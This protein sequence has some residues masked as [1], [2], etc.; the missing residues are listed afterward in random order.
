MSSPTSSPAPDSTD[1]FV[2]LHVHTEYSM[3]D[4]AA[5]IGDLFTRASELGMPALAMTDH[6]YLYGAHEFWRKAQGTGVKPIIGLEAY[7][8]PGTH[9][10]DKT[11]VKWG[12][13][14]TRPG[15][16][17]SGSGAYTHMTL[18][19][20]NNN[21]LRN[22]FQMDSRA[23]LD[24][25]Y[26]KWPRLDRELIDQHG[27]G[28]I[29]T[30]GCPSSEIQTR[31][32][33]GQ[34]DLAK[35][36]ASDYRD[37]FGAENY[38]CEVM[39]HQNEIE[40]RTIKDLLRLAKELDLPLLATND[41]HYTYPED[42]QAHGALLCVQSGSTLMDPNRFKF[43]GDG[44]Y[45]KTAAEMRHTWREL[46][47]ACDNTLLVAEMCEVSFTEGEGRYMPKFPCPP[48]ENEQSWFVKEVQRGLHARFPDGI[49]EYAQKQADF[50]IEVIVSK[51]YPGYFLVVADFINWAKSNGIRVGPG[52]GSGAGSMCAYAMRITDLDPIPHGL[53]FE[54]FLNP[55]RASMPDFDI[56][57][58]ERRRGEVIRYVTEKYGSER[59]AQIVTYG[60]IKAKQ[61]VKDSARVM[62]HPFNVGEQLTKAMPPDVMG[63]GVPLSG[64]YDPEHPRYGEGKEFRELVET[65]PHFKE[66]VET[67]KGLEGLKRQWGVHAAG[68]IMSS[69][70]LIDVIPIMKRLQDG[71]VLTQFDYPTCETLGLVKM[72]FLGL[73]NLTILDDA[74]ENVKTN[75]GED[76]D[77]DALS[78]DM[79]DK[80]TYDL[81]ARGDTL[82]V[83]QLDG[84]GMR[85]LLKLMQPD[86]FEDISAALAL[87]RPGPM[88]V[89]AHTNFALRKNGKQ[90]LTP[91]DP[92]LKGKL[93]Q[94]MI[95]ALGPIL[96]T[97]YG[98]VIYQEQVM[99]IAQKLAGYTLGNADLL[100]RAM[101]KKKKEVLDAEYIPFSTGMKE[102]GFN[103]ASIAALWGVLVPFSDYAFNK[104]HTAA[105][106]LV[107][108]WT[109]YLKA[110]Y[111]AEYM[112][113]LLTSVG[114]DKD[115]SALYLGECRR[116]GIK[117]LPPDVNDSVARFAAVGADIRFG[118]AAIRN[119]GHNVVEAIIAAR[120]E[121]GAFTSFRDF[122]SKCPAVVCNKRTIESLI[123]GGA[124]DGLG[125]SRAGLLRVHEEYVD[126]FVAIKRQEAIGQDSLFGAFGD[127]D[128]SGAGDAM[129]GLTP[130]P[131]V[132][133]DKSTLLTFE[134]E[135]L[136]LYVSD[137]PLFGVEHVLQQH[138]DTA[139]AT[140]SAE[141]GK[142][143]GSMVTVAGLITGLQIKRTKKGDLW[144]IATVEDLEG[145]IECLFFP[146]AYLTVSTMLSQDVVAVVRGK[147]NRRD[148]S[149]SI[150]AQELTLPEL[151]EGPRGPVVV[152]LDTLRATTGRMEELKGVLANH[153]GTTEVHL[154][155]TKP[156]RTTLIRLD[157]A[158]R[159]NASESLYGDLKVLLGPRCLTGG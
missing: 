93:Q 126:A 12:D 81:L 6:G 91:L 84:G 111:P 147:V 149:V 118:M 137:H 127:D 104:A 14:R 11:R 63:K 2:H 7:V 56:D 120:E 140:L 132:E 41:S 88:G 53:I 26:A 35:Q 68:V 98:L 90:E 152:T 158:L 29:A 130:V 46:P 27:Q 143:E 19:A 15:D 136:G 77:L 48:G 109:A 107:S 51:G 125:E 97:T 157:D 50:E 73:R 106:G 144:A 123:K 108:Y 87:Y 95:D 150:Y 122:L 124:F 32:R 114:D 83:F 119:V 65:E 9:R 131:T 39:D 138:A 3:L 24:Q 139:I 121:K 66:I 76:L 8:T 100:R 145:A 75:R 78:K 101:G 112:A 47:E 94:E 28:L 37:I 99:E 55:E 21:G 159:V 110:N 105:Y 103:E 102:K 13:E 129:M 31:L 72:D 60:T 115:K 17:V 113:G 117:V 34:Y 153:P 22:L 155:L 79:T 156:G 96:G 1:S 82:G 92:Q 10:T 40:R 18:L 20:K 146:S 5:R 49:P 133:W 154:K 25:V 4:G 116:M 45:L 86:N 128:D 142:P 57:F 52:R 151:T 58:D 74:I 42:S 23:S 67:A 16:D 85:T 134:R 64:I 30:T 148:D 38:F 141:D 89:N 54:R 69:E 80:A 62:G 61:A 33:L 71:Q 44:Y 135:M 59:V 70:P 36:A 43:D